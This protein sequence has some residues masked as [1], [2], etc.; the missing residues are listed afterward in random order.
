MPV[1]PGGAWGAMA[2]PVF[3]SSVNPISSKGA[4]YAHQII[5]APPDFFRPSYGPFILHILMGDVKTPQITLHVHII[6]LDVTYISR[7]KLILDGLKS[8]LKE[9]S[10]FVALQT[11]KF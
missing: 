10:N 2:H 7:V 11:L 9:Y 8:I 1:V 6:V 4:D 3:G 5:L